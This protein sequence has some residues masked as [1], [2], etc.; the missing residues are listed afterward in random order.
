VF[1]RFSIQTSAGTLDIVTDG[2]HDFPQSLQANARVVSQ[3]GY[4]LILQNNYSSVVH[5]FDGI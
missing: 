4:T 1:S 2:F 3:L 5:P